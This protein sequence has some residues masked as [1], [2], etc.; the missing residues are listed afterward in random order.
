MKTKQTV[1]Y[2]SILII[3]IVVVINILSDRFFLRLDLT[4]DHRADG[5]LSL[6]RLT[7]SHQ[8]IRPMF[9]EQ[10]YRAMTIIKGEPYHHEATLWQSTYNKMK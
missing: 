2:F 5:L 1:V 7:F 3:A 10:L 6:S 9:V 4:G 8:M